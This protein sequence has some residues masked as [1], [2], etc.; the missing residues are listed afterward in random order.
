[1][2]ITAL[3]TPPDPTDSAA[4]FNTRAFS[5]LGALPNFV[6]EANATAAAVDAA[7]AAGA[8]SALA[9]SNSAA[10][11]LANQNAAA[12]SAQ[13]A[14]N[15]AGAAIWVSGTTYAIGDVR[16]SPITRLVYRRTTA[17]AG[18]TDPSADATNW[19]LAAVALPQLVVVTATAVAGTAWGQFALT[20]TGATTVTLPASPAVGDAVW[21]LVANGRID[22]V[23]ARAGNLLQGLAEDLTIDNPQGSVC[24]RYIGSTV[25]WRIV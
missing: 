16:W 17:G 5:L 18:S 23:I 3:P 22:N 15:S 8:A 9:A 10:A 6:T 20:A 12:A 11:A 13:A 14:A 19:A 4:V 21:V 25:G 1:M 2:T 24:L 7:A